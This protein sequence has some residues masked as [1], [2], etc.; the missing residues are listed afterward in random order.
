MFKRK[1]KKMAGN[2]DQYS[3][4]GK[5]EKQPNIKMIRAIGQIS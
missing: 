5:G 1:N 4:M 2:K 3:I